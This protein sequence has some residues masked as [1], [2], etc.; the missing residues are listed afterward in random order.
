MDL[1]HVLAKTEQGLVWL[2]ANARH[3]IECQETFAFPAYDNEI[4]SLIRDTNKVRC[5]KICVEAI[6]FDFIMS[7]MRMYDSYERDT[8]CF[9]NL[10]KCLTKEFI[11]E[12]ESRTQKS[13][14]DQVK[15]AH[16]EFQSINGSHFI[17]S[18]KTV[19]HKMLAHTSSN[20]N[21]N[22]F[23]EYGDAEKLLK[24]TLPMLNHINFAIRDKVESY[25]KIQDYWKGYAVEFWQTMLNNKKL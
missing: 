16:D 8:I 3:A 17:R 10:F 7:L 11:H 15:L 23:P 5:Y 13:I 18:L 12:F 24:R 1:N 6:Y 9:K 25:D 2:D 22:K 14:A 20:F 4:R 19:R 21:R